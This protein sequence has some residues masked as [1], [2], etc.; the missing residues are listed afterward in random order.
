MAPADDDDDQTGDA[1]S[2]GQD[3]GSGQVI[4]TVMAV[5]G[6]GYRV[7]DGDEDEDEDSGV[8][9]GQTYGKEGEV[10]KAVLECLRE[11]EGE[12][13]G[14]GTEADNFRAAYGDAPEQPMTQKYQPGG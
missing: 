3:D 9:E 13:S 10:L 2:A 6:G 7:I 5:A 12:T 14:E 4:C 8:D 1:P 11:H